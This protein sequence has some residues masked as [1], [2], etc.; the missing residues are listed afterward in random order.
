MD[1][2]P[3]SFAELTLR[4]T[5]TT[6]QAAKEQSSSPDWFIYRAARVTAE[7]WPLFGPEALRKLQRD[8]VPSAPFVAT[9]W[10]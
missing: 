3:P 7:V 5:K 6:E 8:K 2:P 9:H 10:K 1:L 4:T